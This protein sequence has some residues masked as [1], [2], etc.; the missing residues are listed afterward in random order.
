MVGVG[1]KTVWRRRHAHRSDAEPG[2]PS[3]LIGVALPPERQLE[4][5]GG[6]EAGV[7]QRFQEGDQVVAL[8]GTE[9]EPLDQGRRADDTETGCKRDRQDHDATRKPVRIILCSAPFLMV[10]GPGRS[11]KR[12]AARFRWACAVR[13]QAT[14]VLP[15][16]IACGMA[17][18]LCVSK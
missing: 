11:G 15:A 16:L 6:R 9:L 7:G 1:R 4:A 2:G 13:P 17:P 8:A 12:H 3:R 10:T 14:A 18:N 5:L